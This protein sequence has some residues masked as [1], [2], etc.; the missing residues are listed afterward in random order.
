MGSGAGSAV[1]VTQTSPE[2][3]EANRSYLNW[4]DSVGAEEAKRDFMPSLERAVSLAC[5]VFSEK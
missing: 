3:L 4:L 1:T 5:L 2:L